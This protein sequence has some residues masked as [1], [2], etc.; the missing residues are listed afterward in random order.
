MRDKELTAMR[1]KYCMEYIY[2]SSS[3]GISEST[4][5]K[6]LHTLYSPLFKDYEAVRNYYRSVLGK[7]GWDKRSM[8]YT[9]ESMIPFVVDNEVLIEDKATETTR[10][11]I[12]GDLHEPFS[13]DGYMEFCKSVYNKHNCNGVIFIGDIL[14]NHYQSFHDTDADGDSALEE[15]S[16]ANKNIQ[17]WYKLFP[18]AKVC[19]GNHDLIPNRKAFKAGLSKSWIKPIGEMLNT[20]N[21]EYAE[22]FVIDGVLYTHGTGR[23]AKDRMKQDMI[24]VVQ[25]HYHSESYIEYSVGRKH[26]LYAMQVG[27][28]VN[29]DTYAMAYGKNFAKPHI[30]CGVVLENGELPVLIY[31]NI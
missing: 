8:F 23:K 1:D 11:L 5:C 12:V 29:K 24:S 27:C 30:N 4:V 20:P 21:W 10:Y 18:K 14:D 6:E 28:G 3:E 13:L 16:K 2:K 25:G 9:I 7:K 15:F 26:K 17:K 22:E 19:L 31:M